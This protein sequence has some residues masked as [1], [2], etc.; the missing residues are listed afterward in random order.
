M[1]GM[2]NVKKKVHLL[3]TGMT[4]G[5]ETQGGDGCLQYGTDKQ[6]A[7]AQVCRHHNISML[8]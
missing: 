3:L 2:E 5:R 6:V 4:C 8:S 1:I 7:V